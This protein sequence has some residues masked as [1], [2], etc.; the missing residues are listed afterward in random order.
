MIVFALILAAAAAGFI[1][2]GMVRTR[3]PVIALSLS[4]LSGIA[5]LFAVNLLGTV[6]PID[7]PV[8]WVSIGTGALG[9][10]PGIIAL[11]IMQTAMF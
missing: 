9:G 2:W 11:L 10:V 7:L 4:A 5:A 1:I 3:R 6:L 8:N